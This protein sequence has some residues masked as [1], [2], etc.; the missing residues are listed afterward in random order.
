MAAAY[1]LALDS[2]IKLIEKGIT[3]MDNNI[4]KVDCLNKF[5]Y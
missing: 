4:V 2:I 1:I 5:V 3:V